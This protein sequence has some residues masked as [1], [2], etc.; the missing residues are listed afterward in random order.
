MAK[1]KLRGKGNQPT[2]QQ[3]DAEA[4]I[5]DQQRMTEYTIREYPVEVLVSKYSNGLADGTSEIY[6]PDYQ[7]DFVW[8]P[9]QKAKFIESVLIGLPIPY[10]FAADSGEEGRE[11]TLEIIDGS[12][13]L[14]TLVEF[15]EDR[16][17]L[18]KLE[19][20]D[21]LEGFRFS[22]LLPSRQRRFRRTT[23]R[24]IELNSFAN[25]ET[26]LDMF[27]RLNTGGT[28]LTFMETIRGS[29]K[30]RLL[31][32][33]E[34]CVKDDLFNQ[35]CPISKSRTKRFERQ[36]LVLRFFAYTDRYKQFVHRVDVFLKKF[37]QDNAEISDTEIQKFRAE[38]QN[39][40]A[41]VKASFP[42]GF[43]RSAV[44]SSVP[45]IRFEAI[46]IGSALALRENSELVSER[47]VEEW[48][49]SECFKFLTRSDASNNRTRVRARFE[50]VKRIL[51][52][53]SLENL[54]KIY[55]PSRAD[56]TDDTESE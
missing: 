48:L 5:V 21:Q 20:L 19:K 22:D 52:G 43:R 42:Y 24:M 13:R 26:R 47:D 28:K 44:D 36:E 4:Q 11:G 32:L 2:P 37:V 38:F 6:I 33:I 53:E 31:D 16:L 1:A 45:R 18:K 41:F 34:E 54:E 39:T 12:Q 8:S 30:G 15:T 7:R 29:H 3:N 40:L 46:A 14:R 27:D 50:F 23:I 9:I 56:D 10:L 51:L 55:G 35:L 49:E 17:K 25:E